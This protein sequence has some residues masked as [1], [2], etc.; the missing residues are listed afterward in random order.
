MKADLTHFNN[1]VK[2]SYYVHVNTYRKGQSKRVNC[3]LQKQYFKK[4][5]CVFAQELIANAIR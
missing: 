1:R 2:W 4:V 3:P 5:I